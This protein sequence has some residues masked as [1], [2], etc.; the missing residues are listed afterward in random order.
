MTRP[1]F[2]VISI[3]GSPYECGKQY[4]TAARQMIQGNVK[5]YFERWHLQAGANREDILP[6]AKQFVPAISEYDAAT[7]EEIEGIADGAGLT[8]EEIVALN[9]RYEIGS[10]PIIEKLSPGCTAVAVL[11]LVTGEGHTLI[12]QNWDL[13]P[14]FQDMSIILQVKQKGRPPLVTMTEAGVVGHRGMNAAGVA[15]CFNA[16]ASNWDLSIPKTPFL[17]I[18]RGILNAE[19]MD[20]ALMAVTG[21]STTCSGNFLIAHRDGFAIDL[22]VSPKDVGIVYDRDG[23]LTHSNHFL[24]LTNRQGMRDNFKY[25]LPDTLIRFRRSRQ[26]LEMEKGK[27]GVEHLERVFRDHLGYPNSICRHADVKMEWYMRAATLSSVIMDLNEGA[28][29]VANGNPCEND[30]YRIAPGFLKG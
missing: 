15:C 2:P 20:R 18:A 23:I 11:P 26:L 24:E 29:N 3:A 17:V 13:F 6:L 30:Y 4:G 16:L 12:G 19:S 8:L 10:L 5:G 25:L 27:I 7:M 28:M 1:K 14:A 9:A 22:E 21:T